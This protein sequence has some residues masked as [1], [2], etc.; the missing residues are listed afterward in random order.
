MSFCSRMRALRGP[1]LT[2]GI[3]DRYLRCLQANLVWCG[4]ASSGGRPPAAP[5]QTL[6]GP[7]LMTAPPNSSKRIIEL[8]EK[9]QAMFPGWK[10]VQR[11]PG[12]PGS[13]QSPQ[14]TGPG[15]TRRSPGVAGPM[16]FG[17]GSHNQQTLAQASQQAH[18][19]HAQFPPHMQGSSQQMGNQM[20]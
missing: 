1:S 3:C 16:G 13:T 6:A 18:M 5:A 7:A 8:Y 12:G 20:G 15:Q 17:A 14:G 2:L 19:Q 9:L 10:G 11:P 4:T